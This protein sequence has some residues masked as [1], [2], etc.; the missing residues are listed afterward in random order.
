M[1]LGRARDHAP[2]LAQ[3]ASIISKIGIAFWFKW[4]EEGS[5]AQEKPSTTAWNMILFTDQKQHFVY[6]ISESDTKS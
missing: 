4:D 1:N 2:G 6:L 3:Y 5:K